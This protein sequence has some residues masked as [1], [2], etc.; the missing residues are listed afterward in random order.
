MPDGVFT[1]TT[2][3][4]GQ[5]MPGGGKWHT[6]WAKAGDHASNGSTKAASDRSVAVM[7][8]PG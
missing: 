4:P 2:L 6:V 3:S 1:R 8:S 5:D 7:V